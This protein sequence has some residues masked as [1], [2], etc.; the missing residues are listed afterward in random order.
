MESLYDRL[1]RKKQQLLA[2]LPR[3]ALASATVGLTLVRQR[4]E[5]DGLPGTN[6]SSNFIPTFLFAGRDLNAGGAR[7]RK[8]NKMGNWGQYRA[9]QGLSSD[10]VNLAYTNRMWNSLTAAPGAQTGAV[11][12]AQI[13]SA[14]REGADKVKHNKARY[15]DFL[16]PNAAEATQVAAV[17]DREIQRILQAP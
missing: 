16:Q 5:R 13:V 4:I 14:D 7:Y 2:A 15:G 8:Q 3:L 17:S 9:A 1:E 12:T 11:A 6:Y 10:R